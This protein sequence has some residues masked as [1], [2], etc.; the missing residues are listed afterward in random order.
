MLSCPQFLEKLAVATLSG[1]GGSGLGLAYH[2]SDRDRGGTVCCAA[3]VGGLFQLIAGVDGGAF[4]LGVHVVVRGRGA[5]L[6]GGAEDGGPDSVYKHQEDGCPEEREVLDAQLRRPSTVMEGVSSLHVASGVQACGQ[7]DEEKGQPR[8]H[9]VKHG[10]GLEGEKRGQ[11]SG[12]QRH[13]NEEERDQQHG[14]ADPGQVVVSLAV[15]SKRG[16]QVGRVTEVVSGRE[17]LSGSLA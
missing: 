12:H 1:G 14:P 5:A 9:T 15:V 6:V 16:R 8:Q 11:E 10:H 3:G 2:G 17:R 7:D 4:V 13:S